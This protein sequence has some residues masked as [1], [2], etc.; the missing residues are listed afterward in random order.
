MLVATKSAS[1]A[2]LKNHETTTT[3]T[4]PA[5]REESRTAKYTIARSRTNERRSIHHRFCCWPKEVR[6]TPAQVRRRGISSDACCQRT[7]KYL[8]LGTLTSFP[9]S[10][11]FKQD[12]K[13]TRG[14]KHLDGAKQLNNALQLRTHER[15][16]RASLNQNHPDN[17]TKT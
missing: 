6:T 9:S 3:A 15:T 8:C 16:P 14:N 17:K 7:A 11:H 13:T 12:S 1:Q 2:V 5:E 10:S 4:Y